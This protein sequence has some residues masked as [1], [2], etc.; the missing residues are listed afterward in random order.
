MLKILRISSKFAL[1]KQAIEPPSTDGSKTG[2]HSSVHIIGMW[3]LSFFDDG[4]NG[5]SAKFT[6][7]NSG[8]LV[9]TVS[10]TLPH[11]F[12]KFEI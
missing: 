7:D 1:R 8:T 3:H 4:S 12:L 9:N 2:V 10:S 6:I 11:E 5:N